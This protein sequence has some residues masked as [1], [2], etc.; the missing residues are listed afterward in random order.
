MRAK[1]GAAAW[2]GWLP[3]LDLSVARAFTAKSAEHDRLWTLLKQPGTLTL[4][5]KLDL[6]QMLRPAVQ[7]GSTLDYTLPDEDV[8]VTLTA[9]GALAV[10]SPLAVVEDANPDAKGRRQVRLKVH[11]KKNEPIPVEITLE[12]GPAVMLEA[13]YATNEDARPRALALGRMLVPWASVKRPT[14]AALDAD[15]EAP[16]LKGGDW[17]RGREIFF[18]EKNLCVK[19]HQV[20]GRGGRIGPDLS[21]LIHRDY[22]S[23]LRD[24]HS[25]SAAIN[26]DY[27]TY[28][29]D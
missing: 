5:T 13:T 19:C 14:D 18:N 11:P 6:W 26:P 17:T 2:T 16:E 23:V 22:V 21:N 12:T 20:R 29:V 4:R 10:K 24:I 1:A 15:R 27:I 8:T 25:P 28:F 3:H 7:P 9:T